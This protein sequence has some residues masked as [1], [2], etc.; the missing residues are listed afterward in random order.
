MKL[1]EETSGEKRVHQQ[2]YNTKI[3][4]EERPLLRKTRILLKTGHIGRVYISTFL[5]L[6]PDLLFDQNQYIDALDMGFD[7][8]RS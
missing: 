4:Y 8:L 6:F 1:M 2:I 7:E 5:V 3:Y